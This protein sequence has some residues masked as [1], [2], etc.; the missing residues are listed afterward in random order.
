MSIKLAYRDGIFEPIE[1]VASVKPGNAVY[2]T[3]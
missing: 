3:L 1:N 2:D